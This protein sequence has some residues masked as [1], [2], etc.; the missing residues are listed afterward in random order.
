MSKELK[1]IEERL[2]LA[3]HELKELEKF[4]FSLETSYLQDS[5][6]EGNILKGWEVLITS[7]PSKPMT[8]SS[9]KPSIRSIP[10]K[11]RV[12]SQSS[13]KIFNESNQQDF[14][15]PLKRNLSSQSKTPKKLK[16]KSSE[17][18]EYSEEMA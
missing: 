9:K 17:T 1:K 12:F 3:E 13:S 10:I 18:D 7:K 5:S 8:P 6:T 2:Q 4:I 16:K 11:D 15:I 14:S